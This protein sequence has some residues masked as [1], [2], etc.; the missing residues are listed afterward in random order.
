LP[1]LLSSDYLRPMK[2]KLRRTSGLALVIL[3]TASI[4]NPSV[5]HAL[6]PRAVLAK[7]DPQKRLPNTNIERLGTIRVGNVEYAIYYLSFTNPVSR[8]GQERIA[9][10]KNRTTFVGSHQCTLGREEG[11][12]VVKHD[13]VA[14]TLNGRTSAI[15]FGGSGPSPDKFFCGESTGWEHS[16]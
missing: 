5:A 10:I 8:H 11:K 9:V 6:S 16:I 2:R 3:A 13:R 12:V 15:R 1:T 7:H 14:V 4:A